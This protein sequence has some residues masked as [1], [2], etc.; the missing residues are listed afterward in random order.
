[1]VGYLNIIARKLAEWQQTLITKHK[2]DDGGEIIHPAAAPLSTDQEAGG[3]S[4]TPTG[5]REYDAGAE[6]PVVRYP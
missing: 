3:A 1:M 5:E 4:S 6:K 2:S